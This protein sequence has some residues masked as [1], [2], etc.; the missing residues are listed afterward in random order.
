MNLDNHL[1]ENDEFSEVLKNEITKADI[2]NIRMKTFC[3]AYI[4]IKKGVIK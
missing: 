1:F 2:E 3:Y 4:C